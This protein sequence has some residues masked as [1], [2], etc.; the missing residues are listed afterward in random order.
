MGKSNRIK[1]NKQNAKAL[2]LNDYSKPKKKNMPNW[3]INLISIVVAVAILLSVLVIALSSSGIVLRVRTAMASDNYKVNGN[4][5]KY[6]FQTNY[7]NFVTNYESYMSYLSLD[8]SKSLKDQVIGDTSVNAN[9]IDTAIV[10]AEYEGKTWYDYFMEATQSDVRNMLYYCEEADKRNISLDDSDN[11]II[12]S[13]IESIRLTAETAG[14]TTNAYLAL[15]FGKGISEKDVRSAM[16]LSS[17]SSKAMTAIAEELDGKITSDRID[18]K[19]NENKKLF[20]VID[21]TYYT[22]RINYSDV[23]SDVKKANANASD[24]DVLNAYKQ[25]IADAKANAET[26]ISKTNSD[27]FEKYYLDY[28]AKDEFDSEYELACVDITEGKPSDADLETIKTKMAE[29]L[30]KEMMEDKEEA[31]KAAVKDGDKYTVY[32]IEVSEALATA[33][34]NTKYAIFETLVSSQA[35]YVKDSANFVENDDFS[36]W[37]FDSARQAGEAHKIYTGDGSEEGKDITASDKYFYASVYLL[38]KTQYINNEKAR[39][40]SYMLFSSAEEARAAIDSLKAESSV[41]EEVF[42]HVAHELGS[43]SHNNYE[44]YL[45]GELGS[46]EFDKWL[47]DSATVVGSFNESPIS[48]SDGSYG[49]FLYESDGDEAWYVNV[50]TAILDADFSAFSAEMEETYSATIKVNNKVCAKAAY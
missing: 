20:D 40:V 30:V 29:D 7:Q 17:L 9:A 34:D 33:F 19:Y 14:Y 23:E 21:Y 38:R 11:E 1:Q 50:K 44:N 48:L 39:N 3:A 43:P 12:D 37:A 24:E 13:S 32:G 36:T 25:A 41:N 26:L 27:D 46:A 31:G 45:K 47:Y 28:I 18:A 35:T 22:F 6:Y 15:T 8:T 4:M 42:D 10:G 16:K 2:S 5:M 49:V